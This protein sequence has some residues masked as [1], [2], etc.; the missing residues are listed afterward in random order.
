MSNGE[1]FYAVVPAAGSGTRVGAPLPK[2]YL[3]LADRTV[4]EWSLGA[5]LEAP[6]IERVVV[7]VAPE[8]ARA[9]QMLASMC[10]RFAER[11][12]LAPVGGATRRDSV[13]AG[14]RQLQATAAEQDWVLV[15]DAA[16]PGL[17]GASL[18]AL[19][20]ALLGDPVGGL[21][22]LPVADTVKRAGP[23]ARVECTVSREGL[24]LAQTPQMFRYGLL[25][26]ALDRNADVTDEAGA[27]EADG[28]SPRLVEGERLNFKITTA[29]DLQLMQATLAHRERNP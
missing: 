11:L 25:R 7:V 12:H 17:T 29:Q 22:A 6:W 15:H 10:E 19:R 26:R 4:L 20:D 3:R 9:R 14:L 5:L 13:L 23:A 16:R 1:R 28:H 2:Q 21:L 27:I 8:D 18:Q 24:W